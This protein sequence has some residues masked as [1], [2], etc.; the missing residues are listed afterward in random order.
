MEQV[1]KVN[2]FSS[3]HTFYGG[4][5]PCKWCIFRNFSLGAIRKW[6][7]HK[8]G[9]FWTPPPFVT[10][11]DYFPLPHLFHITPKKLTNPSSKRQTI[12]YILVLIIL[13]I[14]NLIRN[15][16]RRRYINDSFNV[17]KQS[18]LRSQVCFLPQAQK[19]LSWLLWYAQNMHTICLYLRILY[20]ILLFNNGSFLY[21]KMNSTAS[22]DQ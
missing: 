6:C 5:W 4:L 2:T 21:I 8:I 3:V 22:R 14:I 19:C 13:R 16:W 7:H 11:C 1:F 20:F 18:K 9:N 10:I 15:R 17:L 12:K